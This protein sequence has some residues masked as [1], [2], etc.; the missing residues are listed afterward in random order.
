MPACAAPVELARLLR[1]A[2]YNVV[3]LSTI[4]Q[5]CKPLT[6]RLSRFSLFKIATQ[7]PYTG[8]G[9]SGNA[10]VHGRVLL[11]RTVGKYYGIGR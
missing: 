9:V 1:V 8:R 5:R 10:P 7:W 2:V 11:C 6:E 4:C 3:E